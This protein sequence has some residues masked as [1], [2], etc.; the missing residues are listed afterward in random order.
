MR[1]TE[2]DGM[3][4]HTSVL[5]DEVLGFLKLRPGMKVL[6]ATVGLGGHAGE[7]LKRILPGGELIAMD[8]DTESLKL[9]R[10]ELQEFSANIRWIHGNFRALSSHLSSL[11]VP[12][13]DGILMDVGFSSF[14]LDNRVRGFSFLENAPLDMRM[15]QSE[16]RPAY[17]VLRNMREDELARVIFIYGQERHARKIARAIVMNRSRQGFQTTLQLAR[18]IQDAVGKY[19]RNQKIHS[20]TRTFQALRIYVNDELKALEEAIPQAIDALTPG[21]RLVVISFHSLE[22]GIVKRTFRRNSQVRG[23]REGGPTTVSILT[24]KP[25]RPS[26][27]E[28]EAN[29]RARSARL[30]AIERL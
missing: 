8:Q 5:V 4:L 1:Y 3:S 25:V 17:E 30:R 21:G 22:D 16:G 26:L 13:V 14:Q 9:A 11:D 27:K 23:G 15:D 7:I 10:Q 19:Y 28:I 29:P 12:K 2:C 18:L 24:R 20:A 6:D